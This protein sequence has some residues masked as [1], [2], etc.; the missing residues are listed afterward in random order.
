MKVL[1]V[2]NNTVV[3][4]FMHAHRNMRSWMVTAGDRSFPIAWLQIWYDLPESNTYSV[5][6]V[7]IHMTA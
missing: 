2:I 4:V 7:V 1:G 6:T 3:S 5:V